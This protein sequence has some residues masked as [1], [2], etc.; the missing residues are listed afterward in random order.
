MRGPHSRKQRLK[1]YSTSSPVVSPG[2]PRRPTISLN[3]NRIS[4]A[5]E[6]LLRRVTVCL[7]LWLQLNPIW[8]T[9]LKVPSISVLSL[10]EKRTGYTR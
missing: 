10:D 7:H 5:L 6:R 9:T 2:P 4:A 3:V 8:N 1:Y